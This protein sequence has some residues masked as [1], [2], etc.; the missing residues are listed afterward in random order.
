MKL[1]ESL[2]HSSVKK[3]ETERERRRKRR[4][5]RERVIERKKKV[6]KY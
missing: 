4:K 1:K 3:G 6:R 5:E 2:I